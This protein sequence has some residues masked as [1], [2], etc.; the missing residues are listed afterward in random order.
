MARRTQKGR[1]TE[2]VGHSEREGVR[3][4]SS[5]TFAHILAVLHVHFRI[6]KGGTGMTVK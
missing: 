3:N 6:G 5:E 4:C 1:N 2:K